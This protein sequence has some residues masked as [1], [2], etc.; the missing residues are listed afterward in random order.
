MASFP[1]FPRGGVLDL[2]WWCLSPKVKWVEDVKDSLGRV[3]LL[4]Q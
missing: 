3:L 4:F 1:T 2:L